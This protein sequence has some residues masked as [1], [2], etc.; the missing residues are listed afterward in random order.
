MFHRAL[1]LSGIIAGVAASVGAFA[2]QADDGVA[3]RSDLRQA[4]AEAA[5]SRRPLLIVF[6]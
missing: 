5:E 3:W 1:I 4:E 2:R 6:R